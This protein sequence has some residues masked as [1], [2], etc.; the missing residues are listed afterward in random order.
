[1]YA[2]RPE[3]MASSVAFTFV[4]SELASNSLIWSSFNEFGFVTSSMSEQDWNVRRDAAANAAI[5]LILFIS[6]RILE[7]NVSSE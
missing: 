3:P 1:M 4:S 6:N 7:C 2:S 5:V